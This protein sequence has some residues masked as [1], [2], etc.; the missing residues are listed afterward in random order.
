MK[1]DA[2]GLNHCMRLD[3][4][5]LLAAG[6]LACDLPVEEAVG[7]SQRQVG[8]RRLAPAA[9][10]EARVLQ[11][12]TQAPCTALV[13]VWCSWR[14]VVA[15][16]Q[17]KSSDVQIHP[18]HV[19]SHRHAAT[20]VPLNAMP[21]AQDADMRVGQGLSTTLKTRQTTNRPLF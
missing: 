21:K 7:V 12:A 19:T 1:A 2:D 13:G 6:T 17:G 5:P 3:V 20:S 11:R 10:D 4:K 18:R 8:V 14:S 9:R 15:R 16:G